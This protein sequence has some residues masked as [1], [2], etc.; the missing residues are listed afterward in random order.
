MPPPRITPGVKVPKVPPPPSNADK[1][2]S[3]RL[4]VAAKHA[5]ALVAKEAAAAA[6]RIAAAEA[7]EAAAQAAA[8]A[9]YAAAAAV[10]AAAAIAEAVDSEMM[11]AEPLAAA[12]QSEQS[13]QSD[14]S[15]PMIVRS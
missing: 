12:D 11:S 13:E 15:V 6:A 14:Q 2:K 9:V 7:T 3:V 1:L 10:H 8:A 4:R 5:A